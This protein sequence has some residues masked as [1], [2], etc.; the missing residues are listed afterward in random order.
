MPQTA[1]VA[2]CGL[3]PDAAAAADEPHFTERRSHE[4]TSDYGMHARHDRLCGGCGSSEPGSA[5]GRQRRHEHEHGRAGSELDLA[6]LAFVRSDRGRV[7]VAPGVRTR[8]RDPHAF[9]VQ[10][11]RLGL[12]RRA[13]TGTGDQP[14]IRRS[15]WPFTRRPSVTW[16]GPNCNTTDQRLLLLT[17]SRGRETDTGREDCPKGIPKRSRRSRIKRAWWKAAGREQPEIESWLARTRSH[18]PH[19]DVD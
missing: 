5:G 9:P 6:F 7:L 19:R 18:R 10:S 3:S 8:R 11:L 4:A 15:A 17:V 13:L 14:H 12:L 1:A 16:A 2:V